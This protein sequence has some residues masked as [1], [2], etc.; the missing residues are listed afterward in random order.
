VKVFH[1]REVLTAQLY[2][3]DRLT[4]ELYANTEPYKSHRR[5][6]APGL[7]RSYERMR[8]AEDIFYTSSQSQPMTVTREKGVLLAKATLGMASQGNRG[9][10]NYFR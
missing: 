2:F 6:T 1:G 7:T 9:F 3:P 4:D 8:N 10:R 5:L